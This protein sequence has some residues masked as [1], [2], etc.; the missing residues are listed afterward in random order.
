[1]SQ[2]KIHKIPVTWEVCGFVE[3]EAESMEKAIQKFDQEIADTCDLPQEAEY[4][5]GSFHRSCDDLPM[6]DAA[7]IYES[8]Q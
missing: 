4:V 1:M 6:G 2:N 7:E 5:D 3:V 8:Y